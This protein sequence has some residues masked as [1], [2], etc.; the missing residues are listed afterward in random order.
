MYGIRYSAFGIRHSAF[1]VGRTARKMGERRRG[2]RNG[3]VY[4]RLH[5]GKQ[6]VEKI[7]II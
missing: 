4:P 7:D 6:E 5:H 3:G 1:G 2:V